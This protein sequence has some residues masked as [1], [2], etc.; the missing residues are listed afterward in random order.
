MELRTEREILVILRIGKYFD[1]MELPDF[2][3]EN[4]TQ[5]AAIQGGQK[6]LDKKVKRSEK[7][8]EKIGKEKQY[9]KRNLQRI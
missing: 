7:D 2:T 8:E 4:T 3:E 1:Q 5:T 9:F 6:D